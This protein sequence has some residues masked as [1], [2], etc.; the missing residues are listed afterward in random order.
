M[1]RLFY[2]Y[3]AFLFL[4]F[5]C[6]EASHTTKEQ[7]TD[8]Q[9][10]HFQRYLKNQFNTTIPHATHYYILLPSKGCISCVKQELVALQELMQQEHVT[11]ITTLS[12]AAYLQQTNVTLNT[13]KLKIDSLNNLD[14]LK[15]PFPKFSGIYITKNEQVVEALPFNI[16]NYSAVFARVE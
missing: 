1:A 11:V 4:L 15:L 9:T 16:E 14:R 3:L 7:E 10:Q 13:A 6:Q 8:I 2:L 12:A 5:S